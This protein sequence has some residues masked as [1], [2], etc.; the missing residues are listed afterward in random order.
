MG[1]GEKKRVSRL[2]VL[3]LCT[4]FDPAGDVVRCY[5]EL[6][7]YSRHEHRLIVRCTHPK[8][9]IYQFPNAAW[10]GPFAPTGQPMESVEWADCVL[11]H[12]TG[13]KLYEHSE[14]IS[15][16]ES[17]GKPAAFRNLN[18]YYNSTTDTFWT[19][20]AY[21][22]PDLKP[23]KLVSSSHVG[24]KDFLGSD[25]FRWLPDLI[26][27]DAPEYSPSP[28]AERSA[29][30]FL[31]HAD[32]FSRMDF[33][34]IERMNLSERPLAEVLQRRRTSLVAIDN[35]SDGH[36]G[37]AGL[38][39]ISMGLPTVTFNHRATR[40]ALDELAGS[41][42]FVETRGPHTE[43]AVNEVR[44]LLSDRDRLEKVSTDTRAW[45]ERYYSSQ[46]I[47]ERYWDSFVEELV[48]P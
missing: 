1:D 48:A 43:D 39:C 8:Q 3:H 22:A 15:G 25:N 10:L 28:F 33:C 17:G 20:N 44:L 6:L 46:R 40:E 2:K 13:P 29:V 45:V 7:K 16:W 5:D 47:I 19:M 34:G 38:E 32:D 18:I 24:A 36:Y 27:T 42:P 30:S 4:S 21:N 23:F 9:N 12:F 26:P 41:S 11:Y 31:K 37:L 35:V 14:P